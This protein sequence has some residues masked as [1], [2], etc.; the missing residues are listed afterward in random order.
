MQS[1]KNNGGVNFGNGTIFVNNV[2]RE[3]WVDLKHVTCF[4]DYCFLVCSNV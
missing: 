2:N 4:R 1:N 3:I